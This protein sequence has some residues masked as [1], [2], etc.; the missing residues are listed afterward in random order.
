MGGWVGDMKMALL[1]CRT[2][3]RVGVAEMVWQRWRRR[4]TTP[5]LRPPRC[6]GLLQAV[7]PSGSRLTAPL[8]PWGWHWQS[9]WPPLPAPAPQAGAAL[10]QRP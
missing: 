10:A 3:P 7:P 2:H 8:L 4:G 5:P 1:C 6:P 9:P